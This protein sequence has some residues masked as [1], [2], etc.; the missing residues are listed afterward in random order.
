MAASTDGR[1]GVSGPSP[2][3][4][5]RRVAVGATTTKVATARP[6]QKMRRAQWTTCHARGSCMSMK[7]VLLAQLGWCVEG[8]DEGLFEKALQL[9]RRF[10]STAQGTG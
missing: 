7:Q 1:D 3:A 2:Y 9:K 8:M 5:G 6:Q 10:E 4:P